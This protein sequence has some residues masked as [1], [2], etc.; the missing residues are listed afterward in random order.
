MGAL[1]VLGRLGFW[2][3]FIVIVGHHTLY[4]LAEG[5]IVLMVGGLLFFPLTYFLWPWFSG[6]WWV[7]IASMAGY[8]VSGIYGLPP[9]D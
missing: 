9:V 2:L 7:F 8:A 3:G 6:L 1:G 5:D 4:R